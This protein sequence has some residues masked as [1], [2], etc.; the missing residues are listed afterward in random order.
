VH[1]AERDA[2]HIEQL[3]L[4]A[5]IGV[6]DDERERPQRLTVSITVWPNEQFDHLGDD[7]ARA[8]DY[9][10]VSA[11][12][13]DFAATRSDKPIETLA[14]ALAGHLLE[15]FRIQR[16]RIELRKFILPKA[17]YAAAIVTRSASVG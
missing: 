4:F 1:S 9:S 6:T 16:V 15:M 8:V 2:I 14:E 10:E 3:E 12:A 5:R 11:A 17:R 13:G 7:V